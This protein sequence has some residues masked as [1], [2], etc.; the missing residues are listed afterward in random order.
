MGNNEPAKELI[1]SYECQTP[2]LVPVSYD[3]TN[4]IFEVIDCPDTISDSAKT[5]S[6]VLPLNGATSG[7]PRGDFDITR[8]DSTH[9]KASSSYNAVAAGGSHDFNNFCIV[10][11]ENYVSDNIASLFDDGN[12]YEIEVDGLCATSEKSIFRFTAGGWQGIKPITQ[13]QSSIPS[14]F[15][16]IYNKS[17]LNIDLTNKTIVVKDSVVNGFAMNNGL[18][19]YNNYVFD[20]ETTITFSG[21]G[22]GRLWISGY[23]GSGTKI[24]IYKLL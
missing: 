19:V 6:M 1:F 22:K 11:R 20:D 4:A 12:D 7:T 8:I 3:S 10:V 13:G 16:S 14:G 5:N 9:I 24:K 18:V 23:I 17:T 2:M 15:H 21:D